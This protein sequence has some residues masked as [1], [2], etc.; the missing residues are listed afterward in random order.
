MGVVVKNIEALVGSMCLWVVSSD[1]V[2]DTIPRC[3]KIGHG[4]K[5]AE[6]VSSV[7]LVG[8]LLRS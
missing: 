4:G 3:D 7:T 8:L 1:A 2:I 6:V 5:S